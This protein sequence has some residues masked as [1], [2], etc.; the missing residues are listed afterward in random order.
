MDSS[1]IKDNETEDNLPDVADKEV[2]SSK[3]GKAGSGFFSKVLF[4]FNQL[5]MLR[6]LALLVGFAASI[7]LGFA[8]V[9]WAQG[10]EYRPLLSSMNQADS[11]AVISVLEQNKIKYKV[12]PNSGVL[13]VPTSEIYEARLKIA[14][15]DAI[16][17]P[18]T[19]GYELLDKKQEL[20][21]SQFMER[22]RYN[23]AVQGEL[24]RTI[25]S[26][27]SVER[28]R[29]HLAIPTQ[30][31]LI[32]DRRKPSASVF[33]T[34]VPG[35]KLE[36][37]QAA[38][39]M[40]LVASSIPEM[41]YEDV[42][43]VDQRGDLLSASEED[44]ADKALQRQ[45]DYVKT[46]EN[47]LSDRVKTIL[48]PVAG[49]GK[50]Q[51]AVSVD[52]DFTA[53]EQSA[54][55]FNPDSSTPR[56]EQKV[57][58][59]RVGDYSPRG[60]PGALSN[61]PPQDGFAPEEAVGKG[62]EDQKSTNRKSQST[63]NFE[64][65]KTLTY[66]SNNTGKIKR[67]T[68]AVALDD[69]LQKNAKT[70]AV[71]RTPWSDADLQRVSALVE[72]AVGFNIARGDSVSVVNTPFADTGETEL[73]EIPWYR[74]P[75]AWDLAKQ[76]L[77]G[78]FV[79]VLIF[80]VLRPMLRNLAASKDDELEDDEGLADFGLLDSQLSEDQVSLSAATDPLLPNDAYEHQLNAIRA[81]IAENPGRVAQVIRQWI[82]NNG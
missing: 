28:A 36:K 44:P 66:T 72:D 43:I 77:A 58:E 29:V 22:S 24:A 9:L 19:V 18:N 71:E 35:K 42:T 82:S 60:I 67:I 21:T 31:V 8:V 52:M 55:Q 63:T 62:R 38:A 5:D 70:G 41:N 57:Q 49:V 75:W 79:L 40:R 2:S 69:M 14:G 81:L 34:I 45:L 17:Q 54:E 16:T 48:E 6:Q 39:I 74:E 46:V 73:P 3:G 68:V 15:S 51:A 12:D 47:K 1:L 80:G 7:A 10:D 76:I 37:E 4:G 32:R 53:V 13:L 64:I 50:F 61:Q 65:D 30:S 56:S 78:L 23:Q 26:L 27:D 33:L 25:A 11:A 59:E 20:G